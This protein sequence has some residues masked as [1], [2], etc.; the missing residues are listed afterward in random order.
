MYRAPGRINIIGEHTD[1]ND[2]FVLPFAI[3]KYITLHIEKSKKFIFKSKNSTQEIQ[4]DK[5]EK[6]N[7]WADY[8]VGVIFEIE[9]N[10]GK[11]SP[12][13]FFINS[14]LPIGAGLSSSAA[15]EVVSAYAIND[16]LNL[17]LSLEVI[18]L[19]GWKAENNFVGL[20]CGIMDQYAVA[21]SKKNHALFIDTYTKSYELIP[22]NLKDYSFY[23]I[24]SGIK[25]ELGNSE[26]NIRRNQCKEALKIIGKKTFREISY[27]DLSKLEGVYFKRAKHILDENKRVLNVIKSLK[28]NDIETV[29][30]LLFESHESLKNLYEVSCEEIDFIVEFLK[31]KVTGA[32]IV[33]GGFGGSV[34]VLSKENVFE[35]II[36]ILKYE[37]E[38][39]FHI[40]LE[41][42]K[43]ESTNGVEKKEGT[44]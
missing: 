2:G 4:L 22:L 19:I 28:N 36:D 17:N 7:T 27:K 29:G 11:V 9:K 18:A 30:N 3:D 40:N 38:K 39:K 24:N 35:N 41:Y 37:Y 26:Y 42:F 10:H 25:H 12:F 14:N 44:V 8:I 31:N 23:I 16:Q 13:K 20:N 6:T 21:M 1:Y 15:L 34:L 32:R 43:V 5:L 33:G